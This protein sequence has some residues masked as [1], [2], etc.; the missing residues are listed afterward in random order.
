M[1]SLTNRIK[2]SSSSILPVFL[3]LTTLRNAGLSLVAAALFLGMAGWGCDSGLTG[4]RKK[5]SIGAYYFDGWS[6]QHRLANDTAEAWAKNAPT[7][8]SR[9]MVEEFPEREPLWGWRH[10]SME[11]MEKQ[12]D[13][14][15]DN[16]IDFWLFCWYWKEDGGPMNREAIENLPMH[17][18]MNLY[19][20]AKN[21]DRIKFG[22]LVANHQGFQITGTE[23]WGKATEFWMQYFND[24][25]YVKVDGKPLVVIFNSRG[26]EN[27]DLARMQVIAEKGGLNGLSIAGCG[28]TSEKNFSYRTHYNI[29]PGYSAGSEEHKFIEIADAHRKEWAGT[30]Q[31][32]YIP[33]IIVGWDKRPWER[34]DGGGQGW[35]FPDH[36]PQQFKD[37]LTDAILWMDEHPKETPKERMVLVYAWNELGEGGYLVPTKGD[38]EASFLKVIKEVASDK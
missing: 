11:I 19:L 32:P 36:T 33:Q 16:G 14:A 29:I 30:E 13:L 25:Q 20:K 37:L 24:P 23:N 38:P 7:N 35:Y 8:L 34:K 21:K 28:K 2:T 18:S 1:E 12:I 17:T 6:G 10:D 3:R 26:I 22:L 27:E 5:V 4:N 15:A 9:R 31:Q